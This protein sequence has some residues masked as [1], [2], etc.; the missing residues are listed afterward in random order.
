[1]PSG[2]DHED[3]GV[4]AS[5]CSRVRGDRL[6]VF[7]STLAL[8]KRLPGTRS[9]SRRFASLNSNLF[10]A[11]HGGSHPEN[12]ELQHE[13]CPTQTQNGRRTRLSV[14]QRGH[15][16]QPPLARNMRQRAVREA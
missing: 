3:D 4:F 2:S 8:P 13:R 16:V 12:Q 11:G 7:R 15:Q 14:V 9:P 5:A 10:R 6:E 1:M